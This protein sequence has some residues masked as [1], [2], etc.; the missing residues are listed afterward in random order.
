MGISE[1]RLSGRVHPR[2]IGKGIAFGLLGLGLG[3]VCI[4]TLNVFEAFVL[5]V[6]TIGTGA[7]SYVKG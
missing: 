3:V 5:S 7:V 1:V 2:R 6:F 4:F